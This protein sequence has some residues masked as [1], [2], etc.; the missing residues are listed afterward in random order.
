M[1]QI[2][3]FQA[4]ATE[5]EI[6]RGAFCAEHAHE[7]VLAFVREIDGAM[8]HPAPAQI[9]SFIDVKPGG[10]I[11]TVA[12]DALDELKKQLRDRLGIGNVISSGRVRL[13]EVQ[14]EKGELIFDISKG[15]VASMCQQVEAQLK[16]IIDRQMDE[17][18]GPQDATAAE[19]ARRGLQ[20][21]QREHERFGEERARADLFVG[22]EPELR[23][24]DAYL[25]N[26]PGHPGETP[27]DFRQLLVIT[28][29]SGSGKTA[30]LSRACTIGRAKETSEDRQPILRLLGISPHSSDLGG[31]LRSLCQELRVHNP[32]DGEIPQDI[33]ELNK[34]LRDHFE[35]ATA[36]K[37]VHIFLDALDQLSDADNGRELHWLRRDP[38]PEHVKLVVSCLSDRAGKPEGEPLSAL[39][40]RKVPET[41]FVRL[42]G[43]SEGE[44]NTLLFD[45]WLPD[46]KR[47]VT[48]TQRQAI[49]SRLKAPECRQPLYLKIL[50]EEVRLWRSF[51]NDK[52]GD[53]GGDVPKL[54]EALFDRLSAST[55]HGPTVEF[56]MGYLASARR[57][58]KEIE[59]LEILYRE[60]EYAHS[61]YGRF[62]DNMTRQTG[63]RLPND[64]KR[65]PIA[66]WARLRFD[67]APY[68]TEHTAPGGAVLNFYHRN[69]FEAVRERYL[70]SEE[71]QRQAHVRLA[72]Y[73]NAQDYW[74]E[75]LEEQQR[76]ANTLPPTP[77]PANV[78]KVDELPWQLLQA[79]DWPKSKAL[80]I[81]LEFLQAKAEAGM[82]S[83]LADDFNAAIAGVSTNVPD[84]A[85]EVLAFQRFLSTQQDKMA[86]WPGAIFQLA[87]GEPADGPVRSAWKSNRQQWAKQPPF[88]FIPLGLVA[89]SGNSQ[90][91]GTL[92]HPTENAADLH[93]SHERL[94]VAIN[95][96]GTFA[97]SVGHGL[98]CCW[99]L[100]G[101]RCVKTI[102]VESSENR[103]VLSGDGRIGLS[104][105]SEDNR[106]RFWNFETG[107]SWVSEEQSES[108]GAVAINCDGSYALTA[109]RH[110]LRLW[111]V[112]Q[113]RFRRLEGHSDSWQ[114]VTFGSNGHTAM[115]ASIYEC[116]C[117]WDVETG[118]CTKHV[119]WRGVTYGVDGVIL[120]ADA[121][122]VVALWDNGKA[123]G[124]KDVLE[125][126]TATESSM[127]QGEVRRLDHGENIYSLDLSQDGRFAVTGELRTVSC[128][129]LEA[130]RRLFA[131]ETGEVRGVRVSRD[132]R[133]ALSVGQG[134]TAFL[135][136][137]RAPG[138]RNSRP[139]HRSWVTA[140]AISDEGRTALSACDRD[141]YI[142]CWDVAT[143]QVRSTLEGHRSGVRV[144][145]LR[146]GDVALSG[147]YD[148]AVQYWDL[149]TGKS[150][151][152]LR[153]HG[154]P[155]CS[156]ALSKDETYAVSGSDLHD[157]D[158][159]D[160]IIRHD[161]EAGSLI[162][163]DLRTLDY[164]IL[165]HSFGAFCGQAMGDPIEVAITADGRFALCGRGM[166]L[167]H[168]EPAGR[169]HWRSWEA[170]KGIVTK[171]AMNA[172]GTKA[173]S[174][175]YGGGL[176]CWNVKQRRVIC[177]VEGH[178]S[179]VTA[180]ALCA[181]GNY[182]VSAQAD[183]TVRFWDLTRG[184]QLALWPADCDVTALAI[185]PT[186]PWVVCAGDKR[187]NIQ[188]FRL[189]KGGPREPSS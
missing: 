124:E 117:F 185:T 80:L 159:C 21:E 133:Y 8:D 189:E 110:G 112:V 3:R 97:A 116:I 161:R 77:R 38:L 76:R 173:L 10:Q 121:N 42:D 24:I 45:R 75:S 101:L 14:N 28:G 186:H 26:K 168:W 127:G 27:L 99:D 141:A 44:A 103:L 177:A 111:D 128:W 175:H 122:R 53:L 35:S 96:D 147:G 150:R 1:P 160:R 13:E 158:D 34:E 102:P 107:E 33:N 123:G 136:D 6:W 169:H 87:A 17:F 89:R 153:E 182:G 85:N 25:S 154:A 2:V 71:Q 9:R 5:Q 43:L 79:P 164:Q 120:S 57:G 140:V 152:V 48:D 69:L 113:R 94:R 32:R 137:L 90:L 135:W 187:G 126:W 119:P 54:L 74:L 51:D 176:V 132:G 81:D 73:F 95:D 172:D 183:S 19:R 23:R 142:Y 59:I 11:D 149:R 129:D 174:G 36:V 40:G 114:T 179:R 148:R 52:G 84:S 56:A 98:L 131:L 156:V 30:L 37:P 41:N 139:K 78:R 166:H 93:V 7:H 115:S 72:E 29:A 82:V 16:A 125:Y 12:R 62:L 60:R 50:F 18:L 105:R 143:N 46:A 92:E 108:V 130:G 55:N 184:E 151:G 88:W 170:G 22:R 171:L 144:I 178:E 188:F 67:L 49:E 86:K 4:S 155:I 106:V 157:Y 180:V 64:P 181:N 83:E 165:S 104:L 162:R 15:H 31:L 66:I 91:V 118:V 70:S 146:K 47:S 58:L 145:T 109:G 39:E 63:H 134:S 167:S 100:K 138:P 20:Q 163:W 65:I 61:E 68:L